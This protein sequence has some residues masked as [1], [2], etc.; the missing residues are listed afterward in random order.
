M[1]V[2]FTCLEAETEKAN[3]EAEKMTAENE[4]L[5]IEA[6]KKLKWPKFRHSEKVKRKQDKMR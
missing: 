4:R 6:E 1:G 5:K 3:I 2:I